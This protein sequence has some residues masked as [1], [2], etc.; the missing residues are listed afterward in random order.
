MSP[1]AWRGGGRRGQS[2]PPRPGQLA[3]PRTP[4]SR[5]RCASPFS[6]LPLPSPARM[7][8][9]SAA[10]AGSGGFRGAAAPS[11]RARPTSGLWRARERSSMV[12]PSPTVARRQG[13]PPVSPTRRRVTA[14]GGGGR[15]RAFFLEDDEQDDAD[16][17][18]FDVGV[19]GCG[20]G[21][22]G[23]GGGGKRGAKK[24]GAW[25]WT[26]EELE[27]WP[28]RETAPAT[29]VVAVLNNGGERVT[30]GEEEEEE[31][32]GAGGRAGT[33]PSGVVGMDPPVVSRV[34]PPGLEV[35]CCAWFDSMRAR[36]SSDDVGLLRAIS[37]RCS[38]FAEIGS[39]LI[40][41]LFVQLLLPDAPGP[42]F[43]SSPRGV[44]SPVCSCSYSRV[45]S[46]S[47]CVLHRKGLQPA[48]NSCRAGNL[49][50]SGL[51]ASLRRRGQTT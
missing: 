31:G 14:G 22:V 21:D 13:K 23:G 5:G 20:G 4:Y 40:F 28:G 42:W 35:E 9:V 19:D 15:G 34:L 27:A 25:N 41:I 3:S 48:V 32:R 39:F 2:T 10:A 16:D 51:T 29:P 30:D 7:R 17:G 38:M 36:A 18:C 26:S 43:S 33:S 47:R 24:G 11:P 12:A 44:E 45:C 46:L 1:A 50:H 6:R 49:P 8:P 37:R